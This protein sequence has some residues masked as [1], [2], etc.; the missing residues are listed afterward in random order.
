MR[1][2]S[3]TA[4]SMSWVTKTTVL[5]T[6]R[7][8]AEEL[9]LEALPRDGVDGAERLVHEQHVRV[10]AE[11]PGHADPLPLPA[12]Q[13]VRVAVADSGGLQADEVEQLVDAGPRRGPPSSRAGGGRSPRC[14]RSSWWGNRPICWM[15]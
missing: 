2:P 6:S 8:Q 9:V 4:S 15:T 1:S 11:R 3:F 12:G 13:L 14:R 7:L 10:G 5:R